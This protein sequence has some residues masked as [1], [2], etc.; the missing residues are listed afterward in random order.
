MAF[1]C[2]DTLSF[3]AREPILPLSL[4]NPLAHENGYYRLE[5]KP[6]GD[7]KLHDHFDIASLM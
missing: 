5:N 7:R 2:H 3:A 6:C 4:Q 1:L